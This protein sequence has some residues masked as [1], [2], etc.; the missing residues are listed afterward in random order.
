MC[1]ADAGSVQHRSNSGKRALQQI[2]QPIYY[3]RLPPGNMTWVL[4][5][6]NLSA[7]I[8]VDDGVEVDDLSVA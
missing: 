8:D 5:T 4:Q 3:I 6:K 1:S 2:V 7:L